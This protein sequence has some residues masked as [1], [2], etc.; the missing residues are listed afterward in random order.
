ML[1]SNGKALMFVWIYTA[2]TASTTIIMLG[3]IIMTTDEK[4]AT[5]IAALIDM[6]ELADE[7]ANGYLKDTG[8]Y[9]AFDEPYSVRIS[10]TALAKI[11]DL[12]Q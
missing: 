4:L 1:P 9:A 6:A 2:L 7:Y 8:R 12:P 11:I 10:R 5:A 3:S